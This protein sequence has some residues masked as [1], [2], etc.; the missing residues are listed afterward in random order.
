V[1]YWKRAIQI[2]ADL[3]VNGDFVEDGRAGVDLV[4]G[5]DRDFVSCATS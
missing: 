2:T 5:I 1:R 4:R 3:G